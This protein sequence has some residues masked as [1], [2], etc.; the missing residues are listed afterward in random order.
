[1]L[2]EKNVLTQCDTAAFGPQPLRGLDTPI[3]LVQVLPMRFAN[4]TFPPLR[5]DVEKVVEVSE[6]DDD[7]ASDGQTEHATTR[8]SVCTAIRK[9][10][11]DDFVGYL[12][13]H[14]PDAER[15]VMARRITYGRIML[16]T[17]LS[18]SSAKYRD[19]TT[20][21]LVEKWRIDQLTKKPGMGKY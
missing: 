20:K 12:I 21:H 16:D 18:T 2:I 7:A 14:H 5:L 3:P 10:S 6:D 1:L 13:R 15:A 17:M 8:G 4:R 19:T 11:V 9:Y